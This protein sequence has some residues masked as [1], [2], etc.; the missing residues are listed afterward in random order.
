MH[1]SWGRLLRERKM[2]MARLSKLFSLLLALLLWGHISSCGG[3]PDAFGREE[4]ILKLPQMSF[5]CGSTRGADT[6]APV[7]GFSISPGTVSRKGVRRDRYRR[8]DEGSRA[9][10]RRF[11]AN[12]KSKE[13]LMAKSCERTLA[14]LVENWT[15]VT[16]KAKREPLRA[17]VA[18]YL[19]ISHRDDPANGCV[20]AA[21]GLTSPAR[22]AVR[23]AVTEGVRPFIDLLTRRVPGRSRAARRNRALAI[24]ASLVGA[25]VL[26]RVVDDPAYRDKYLRL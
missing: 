1:D 5:L 17:I 14:E 26:A 21:L 23:H 9:E 20:V 2:S 11:Y 16:S 25:T 24:Y 22:A 18:G 6:A 3:T 10:A 7:S 8:P 15:K 13:E 12:F 19:S 4:A